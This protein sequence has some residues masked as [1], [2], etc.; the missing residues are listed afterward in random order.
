MQLI[1]ITNKIYVSVDASFSVNAKVTIIDGTDNSTQDISNTGI[2]GDIDV[3]P[4]TNKIYFPVFN[5]AEIL[6]IDGTDNSTQTVSAGT[7]PGNVAVN[8][9]TNKVYV[10]NSNSDNLTVITPAPTNS[11]PLNTTVTPFANNTAPFST[12]EF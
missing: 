11:I 1:Q 7:I 8:P 10:S 3:N 4:A 12:P 5:N 6:I 2:I 9:I